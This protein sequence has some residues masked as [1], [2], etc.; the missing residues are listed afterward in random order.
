M[1]GS[2]HVT[3]NFVANDQTNNSTVA[4]AHPQSQSYTYVPSSSRPTAALNAPSSSGRRPLELLLGRIQFSFS[5]IDTS[6]AITNT[7]SEKAPETC[8]LSRV[9][10]GYRSTHFVH[11]VNVIRARESGERERCQD[12][13]GKP[14]RTLN[15]MHYKLAF[16][17]VLIALLIAHHATLWSSLSTLTLSYHPS[18]ASES[19]S[20]SPVSPIYNISVR[21]TI[22]RL[23]TMF[24]GRRDVL[25]K[26][27]EYFDPSN[28]SVALRRQR[29]FILY[30]LGGTG[31]TQIMAKFVNDFG[32]QYDTCHQISNDPV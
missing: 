22:P 29:V 15:L 6:A 14:A 26:L 3:I 21:P 27:A 10:V 31:K 28:S 24:T 5:A 9:V 11:A 2:Q 25:Q 8:E 30:G 4:L 19:L 20:S 32:D 7:S 18:P 12:S 23:T 17:I 1:P 16:L 13:D